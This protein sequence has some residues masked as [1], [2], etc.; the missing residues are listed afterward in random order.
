[1]SMTFGP[2]FP[3]YADLRYDVILALEEGGQQ[4]PQ[5]YADGNGYATIGIGFLVSANAREILIAMGYSDPSAALVAA[6]QNA[7]A[8][9]GTLIDFNNPNSGNGRTAHDRVRNALN[10]ALQNNG[11]PR[12]EFR[13]DYDSA[14]NPI[15]TAQW[16][17]NI[18]QAFVTAAQKYEDEVDLWLP[19]G[20]ITRKVPDT[21][22]RL[23]N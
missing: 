18:K 9:N 2:V 16:Q 14:G 4:R 22:R 12:A 23:S 7:V 8:P 19:Q 17:A 5:A 6:I 15:P 11:Y 20:L 1:M 21:F 3:N 10:N 13:F